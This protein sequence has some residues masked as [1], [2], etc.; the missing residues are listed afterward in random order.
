MKTF[1]Q[2]LKFSIFALLLA[3]IAA[4]QQFADPEFDTRVENPAFKKNYPRVLFD[5]AHNNFHT[6]TGRYQPFANLI[7]NDG[8]HVVPGRKVFSKSSLATFK[9]VVIANA[10]GAEDMDEDGAERSAFTDQECDAVRDWVKNGGALLLIADHAPFGAAAENLAHR[11]G[12]EMS[13]GF[14]FDTENHFEDFAPSILLFSRENKRLLDHPITQGR[15]NGEK[16]NRVI[17]FTGQSLKGPDG[18]AV[19]LLLSDTAKDKPDR[20]SQTSVS[21]AGRA[22]GL[23]F[24][25]GKGR[26]VVL[27]EA[28]ML[29]AQLTGAEKQPMGMN[30]P[31][32][33]N[34][35]LALNIMHWL[36]GLL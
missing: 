26:V 19:F 7:V 29:S 5:E 16:I 21:A 1:N 20:Q 27:G 36:S 25:F 14:T 4:A 34:R 33:D 28:A 3:Q 12:V 23:A 35:Q 30:V 11:F 24:K 9:I 18:S 15:T 6:T 31:G 22:Q 2:I 17:T 8:Y 32:S 10:I 13:K